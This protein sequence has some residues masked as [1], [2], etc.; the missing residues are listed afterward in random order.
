MLVLTRKS[1]EAI[2]V[3]NGIVLTVLSVAP[4]RV[5]IGIQ[6]PPSVAVDREEVHERRLATRCSTC[7]TRAEVTLRDER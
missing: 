7:E 6:A 4:G 1:G 3:G 5:R 2:V